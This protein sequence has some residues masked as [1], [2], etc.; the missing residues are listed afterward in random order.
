MFNKINIE[1]PYHELTNGGHI[2]Y[3][4]YNGDP[5]DNLDAFESIVR[6]AHDAGLGYFAINHAVDHCS[7]CSYTGIIGDKCPICGNDGET[8]VS[9]D[10]L[11]ELKKKHS[12]IRIPKCGDN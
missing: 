5:L 12:F 3:V 6:M 4:E 7:L 8:P 11:R 9:I 10:Y 2:T 1:A